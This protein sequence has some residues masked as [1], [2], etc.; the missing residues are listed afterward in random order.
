[1]NCWPSRSDSHWPI[2]LAVMSDDE[3]P[4]RRRTSEQRDELAPS[5]CLS[6]VRDRANPGFRLRPSKQEIATGE[7]GGDDQFALQKS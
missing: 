7:M 5:H 4:G 2:S 3:R 6:R 1:M